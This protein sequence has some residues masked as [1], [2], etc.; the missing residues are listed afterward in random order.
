MNRLTK[1]TTAPAAKTSRIAAAAYVAT[2]A[3]DTWF[4]GAEA[5]DAKR[6]RLITKSALMPLLALASRPAPASFVCCPR[7]L[8]GWRCGTARR[9]AEAAFLGGAGSF[10]IAHGAYWSLWRERRD[11]SRSLWSRPSTKVLAAGVGAAAPVIAIASGR[12]DPVLGGA[13]AAYSVA[14]TA[15]AAQALALSDEVDPQ[16]RR[17]IGAG[18]LAFLASDTILG[19]NMFVLPQRSAVAERAVM[20]TYTIAQGLL[21]AGV[22]R[23]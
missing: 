2:A 14:L 5:P 7:V 18:A 3:I 8:L 19:A 9:L 13:V 12:K 4:A 22:R 10:G 1:A 6:I 16:A 17:L 21:A 23:L 20:A 15:V 11:R